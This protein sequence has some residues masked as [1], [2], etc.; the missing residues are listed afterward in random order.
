MAERA[1]STDHTNPQPITDFADQTT[2]DTDSMKSIFQDARE[3]I[4]ELW[5]NDVCSLYN[6]MTSGVTESKV[7]R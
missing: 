3:K 2:N 1:Y 5:E 7:R 6:L 4:Y